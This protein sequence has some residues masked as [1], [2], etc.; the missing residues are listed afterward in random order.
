MAEH[1]FEYAW[2]VKKPSPEDHSWSYQ[3]ACEHCL[4]AIEEQYGVDWRISDIRFE[5][6]NRETHTRGA[7]PTKPKQWKCTHKVRAYFKAE[8]RGQTDS[9]DNPYIDTALTA[10]VE[11]E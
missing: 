4:K 3:K 9:I 6:L 5:D 1:I 2:S 11:L 10:N 8:H 7:T